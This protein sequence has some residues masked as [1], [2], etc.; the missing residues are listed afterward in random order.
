MKF[1]CG[2]RQIVPTAY[3][4][5]QSLHNPHKFTCLLEINTLGAN[6]T[7]LRC[8][9]VDAPWRAKILWSE[10][11]VGMCSITGRSVFS[12]FLCGRG[13]EFMSGSPDMI[14]MI[15]GFYAVSHIPP[16]TAANI[17][18][19]TIFFW[20]GGGEG[21]LSHLP[22]WLWHSLEKLTVAWASPVDVCYPTYL[23]TANGFH[24]FSSCLDSVLVCDKKNPQLPEIAVERE[25]H[26]CFNLL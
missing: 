25:E 7:L 24:L 9:V 11:P 8:H 6:V 3:T 26:P 21:G 4:R 22:T 14:F 23:I 12:S 20:M 19:A 13:D 2:S 1:A 16:F 15:G 10:K 5:S 18:D 17:Q